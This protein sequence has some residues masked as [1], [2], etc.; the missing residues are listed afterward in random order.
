M[1]WV[2]DFLGSCR[3]LH[4]YI[5]WGSKISILIVTV[6][7]C[8]TYSTEECLHLRPQV[9]HPRKN[10]MSK[11]V[12]LRQ[13][14]YLKTSQYIQVLQRSPAEWPEDPYQG[15]RRPVPCEVYFIG[16]KRKVNLDV[17]SLDPTKQHSWHSSLPFESPSPGPSPSTEA[18]IP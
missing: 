6:V 18:K 12:F 3:R 15:R 2:F 13:S 4:V 1:W 11:S 5:P 7:I 14:A 10:R 17:T 8:S 9:H 16:T